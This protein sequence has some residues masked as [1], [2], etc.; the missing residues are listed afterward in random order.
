[1]IYLIFAGQLVLSIVL[2]SILGWQRQHIGKAAGSR[3]F[4]MVTLGST[5][6]T[7]LSVSVSNGDPSRI[8]AQVLTGIGFIGAGT[9]IHRKDTVEGLTTAAGLWAVS[10]IGM[11]IGFGWYIQAII[12]SILMFI[13]LAIKNVKNRWY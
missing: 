3:T 13:I 8:A 12:A 4:A 2:G 6:F 9:I 5:L 11:A 7:L 10:S 1:M